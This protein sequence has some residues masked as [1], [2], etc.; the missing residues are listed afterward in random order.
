MGL[1]KRTD[2]ISVRV[3]FNIRQMLFQSLATT[4]TDASQSKVELLQICQRLK[5]NKTFIGDLGFRKVQIFE[6][7]EWPEIYKSSVGY[8]GMP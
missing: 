5:M 8:L 7:F 3:D 2:K 1:S 6:V 4:V